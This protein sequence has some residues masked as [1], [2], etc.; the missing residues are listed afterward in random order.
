M[1]LS[2]GCILFISVQSLL[3]LSG[4]FAQAT[5][6]DSDI[7][8]EI[9]AEAA[10]EAAAKA[11]LL[12]KA[13]KAEVED[14]EEEIVDAKIPDAATAA[15]AEVDIPPVVETEE[16]ETP[17]VETPKAEIPE[18]VAP[19][20]PAGAEADA[21]VVE[22]TV[23]FGFS[24]LVKRGS[25]LIESVKNIE[26]AQTKK[27]IAGSLGIFGL[28]KVPGWAAAKGNAVEAAAGKK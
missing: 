3:L 20:K 28:S 1:K 22:E 21:T 18:T 11:E 24:S 9:M 25:D 5:D 10:A 14:E 15:A 13:E 6:D 8:A 7:L 23:A 4:G 26:P 16:A 19:P 12:A 27:I 17:K 2:R